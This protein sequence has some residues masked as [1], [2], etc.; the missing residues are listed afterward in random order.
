MRRLLQFAERPAGV[1]VLVALALLEATV[2]PAP[3]EAM[4]LALAI[5][6][7]RRAWWLGGIAA[8]SSAAGGVAAY[9]LGGALFDE[10]A[11]PLLASRG[12]LGQLDALGALYRDN[13][14]VALV[15]SG[16]TPI[17]YM[18]YT[19]AAG[20]FEVPLPT[21]VAGSLI[22]RAL[23][24]AP[25]AALAYFFGPAARRLAERYAGWVALA[26]VLALALLFWISR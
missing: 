26:V 13:A 4:L 16:Y 3:T 11:R 12:L 1:W 22:G 19:M 23:K 5:A 8:V 17:P 9:Q 2:F 21:F 6:R 15:S 14:L 24:Y 20:A 25:L 18:L 7:P 10:V